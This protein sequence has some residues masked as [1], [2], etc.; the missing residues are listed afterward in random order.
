[1]EHLPKP[2]TNEENGQVRCLMSRYLHHRMIRVIFSF[3]FGLLLEFI[4]IVGSVSNLLSSEKSFIRN[5]WWR[6]NS[7]R[8]TSVHRDRKVP[9]VS[10]WSLDGS[11]PKRL[12]T[13]S[14]TIYWRCSRRTNPQIL[15]C[16]SDW[17]WSMPHLVSI[18][19]V[20]SYRRILG[21]P[22]TSRKE[23]LRDRRPCNPRLISNCCR[24]SETRISCRPDRFCPSSTASCTEPKEMEDQWSSHCAQP[25]R[26]VSE[27]RLKSMSFQWLLNILLRWVCTSFRL[28]A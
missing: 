12:G 11:Q 22:R 15:S 9:T 17:P 18:R 10:N 4:P 24:S 6:L 14:R 19:P 8:R 1:M 5:V 21:Q 20:V 16:S 7:P 23:R 28:P 2:L 27:E 26:R 13:A 3:V 25:K